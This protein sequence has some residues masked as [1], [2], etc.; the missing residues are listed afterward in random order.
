MGLTFQA[1]F[2]FDLT[3]NHDTQDIQVARFM[4]ARLE[5]RFSTALFE[6]VELFVFSE[7]PKVFQIN[8]DKSFIFLL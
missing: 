5:L 3:P 6:S 4:N 1:I 7:F 8:K 2:S